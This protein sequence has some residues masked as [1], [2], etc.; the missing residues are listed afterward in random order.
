MKVIQYMCCGF[1]V[2][3]QVSF[4]E[5]FHDAHV[6]RQ[7]KM[8][9]NFSSWHDFAFTAHSWVSGIVYGAI[10]HPKT[11]EIFLCL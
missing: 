11:L 3:Q 4:S 9:L 7:E 2:N 5:T 6:E 1:T 10:C 8:P